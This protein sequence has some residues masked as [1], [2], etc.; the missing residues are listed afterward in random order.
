MVLLQFV[1]FAL[2][3]YTVFFIYSDVFKK[4][5]LKIRKV[6]NDLS[7]LFLE[8]KIVTSEKNFKHS[9]NHFF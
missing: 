5:S 3:F 8:L 2:V 4:C 1:C 6:L 9:Q 7:V